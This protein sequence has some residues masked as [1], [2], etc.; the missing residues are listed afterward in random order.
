MVFPADPLARRNSE[1]IGFPGSP[2]SAGN[3]LPRAPRL[4]VG[5]SQGGGLG[6]GWLRLLG[7]LGWLG[8]L[9]AGLAGL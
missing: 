4:S 1:S 9:V 7:W 8:W 5:A 6:L 2:G 3:P